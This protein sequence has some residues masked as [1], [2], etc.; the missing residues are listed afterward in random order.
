M[1]YPSTSTDYLCLSPTAA[2]VFYRTYSRNLLSITNLPPRRETWKDTVDRAVEGLTKLGLNSNEASEVFRQAIQFRAVPSGRW[3]WI[4]G[5]E[6]IENP[7]NFSG[8]YNC[9]STKITSWSSFG[10]LMDMAMTGCGTGADLR[11][12]NIDQLAP[13]KNILDV[14]VVGH[15]ADPPMPTDLCDKTVILDLSDES[16][17]AVDHLYEIKNICHIVVGDSREGWVKAYEALF[18]LS[19]MKRSNPEPLEVWVDI[20]Y[21]RA[22]G[23][24]LN[25]FG[26]KSNPVKLPELFTKCAAILNKAVGRQLNSVECCLLIDLA[27]VVVVA[28]NI[29]RSAGIRQ[30]DAEDTAAAEV[31]LNLWQQTETG[32][33]SIDPERDPLRMANHTRVFRRK[34]TL[35]EC[36]D[37]V[38]LQFSC[39]EGAIQWAGESLVRANADLTRD[40]LDKVGFL[41]AF[42]HGE[43]RAFLKSLSQKYN[44]PFTEDSIKRRIDRIGLNPCG[45]ILGQDFFCNLGE[46]HANLLDPGNLQEQEEAFRA[47][48]LATV[49]LLKHKFVD[50]IQQQ[51]REEDPIIGVSATGIFDF[52]VQKFGRDWLLWWGAGRPQAHINASSWLKKEAETLIFWRQVV[53]KTAKEWCEKHNLKVPNRCTTIQPSGTK[54]LL[55]GASPGWH[56]PKATRYIRRITFA[57]NDPVALACIDYGYSVIPSQSDKDEKGNLLDD[58]FD[59]R[60]TEWL[61]EIPIEISWA[62]IAEGIDLHKF[63][64][65]AQFDF[66]MQVQRHYT[67]H[68]SSATIEIRESEIIDM[69]GMIYRAIQDDAGYVSATLLA[70]FDD[71]E[72]FPR[73]PFEPISQKVYRKL[74]SGVLARRK[75]GNF[76]DFLTG[77][78]SAEGPAPCDSDKCLIADTMDRGTRSH[79]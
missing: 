35:Q 65:A 28:G 2:P 1:P 73:L 21:V 76:A 68:N 32:G 8:A 60:C 67:R 18:E 58:P 71:M 33:W 40:V 16:S 45:E 53:E 54:S 31:K 19:S 30:F 79:Q 59:S 12:I 66:F 7:A 57:K 13:I 36:I 43:E 24:P 5:T 42:K 48:T 47:A 38:Q 27:A 10:K 52:F 72:T 61:V 44:V 14:R 55:T 15:F 29:R 17:I 64:A 11:A 51:S 56:P 39:G 69:G 77:T 62:A 75:P 26:G 23:H 3:L 4:G 37:S 34:P 6:W 63:N 41:K 9:S 70:R 22:P 50:E 78:G 74:H 25:G 49:P 20:S 46:V